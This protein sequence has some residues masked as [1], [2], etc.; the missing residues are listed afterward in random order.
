[1]VSSYVEQSIEG[2]TI[3]NS[4]FDFKRVWYD[5]KDEQGAQEFIKD[6]SAIAN[7]Y[8]PDG[9]IVIGFDDKAK[10]FTDVTLP[11][12]P[13]EIINLINKR[14]DRLF[15]IN[16]YDIKLFDHS[17]SIIHIPASLDKPHVIRNY[18]SYHSDGK[19]KQSLQ[20]VIFVRKNTRRD[21]ATRYDLDLMMWD[22]KNITPEYRIIP[23]FNTETI[24]FT[25]YDDEIPKCILSLTLENIGKRPVGIIQMELKIKFLEN[26]RFFD[27]MLFSLNRKEQA[28][29][30][31]SGAMWT[32]RVE[33]NSI[34][35]MDKTSSKKLI[36]SFKQNKMYLKFTPLTMT[37][38]TGKTIKSELTRTE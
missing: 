2:L 18:K 33:L 14:V 16:T 37:L 30:I 10:E 34:S 4:K 32:G 19:E 9:C 25:Q 26:A 13:S 11:I 24:H 31:Q 7:T 29:L 23:S 5:L 21:F 28:I 17:L 35:N 8:G 36:E 1:M 38:S 3:E 27:E 22:N 6:S 12:D 20:N 15:E